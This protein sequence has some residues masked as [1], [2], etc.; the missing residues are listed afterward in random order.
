MGELGGEPRFL[1][2][3]WIKTIGVTV[4]YDGVYGLASA[5]RC[6]DDVGKVG[7]PLADAWSARFPGERD[8]PAEHDDASAQVRANLCDELAQALRVVRV[9]GEHQHLGRPATA[10]G[11]PGSGH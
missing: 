4:D 8:R 3:V 2:A 11:H 1:G 7:N 10:T 6:L 9:L 5:D